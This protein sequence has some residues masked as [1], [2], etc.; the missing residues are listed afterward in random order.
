MPLSEQPEDSLTLQEV[1]AQL[2]ALS[3]ADFARAASLARMC[4]AGLPGMEARDL[5]Q[6][7]LAQLMQGERVWRRG[8]HPLVT[9]KTAMHSISSN[10]RKK[11]KGAIDWFATA[12]DAADSKEDHALSAAVKEDD[13]SPDEIVDARSQLR[14]I[15]SLVADDDDAGLVVT[16]WALGMRG[17]EAA[18]ET[19]L[20]MNRYEAARKRVTKKLE[21]L[22]ALRGKK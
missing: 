2:H 4:A 11:G 14:Y 21:P 6:E 16:A 5:L 17:E 15:E 20:D 19:G 10:A 8:V 3:A 1:S 18:Q 22:A 13:R 7:A 9:L 12:D